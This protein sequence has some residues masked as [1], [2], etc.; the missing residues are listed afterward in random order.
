MVPALALLA[1]AAC[2]TQTDSGSAVGTP[3]ASGDT[4]AVST[5]STSTIPPTTS[6]TVAVASTTSTTTSTSTSMPP[7][8]TTTVPI[9]VGQFDCSPAGEAANTWEVRPPSDIPAP[10]LPE[11]WT[12]AIVGKSVQGRGIEVFVRPAESPR[13][14]V[15]VIGGVHGNEPVT[16]PA[17]RAM[18]EATIDPAI[19]VWL[20]P[21]ANPDGSAAGLRCNANGVDL[22]RN[23]AWEWRPEDGGP[24]PA[25]EPETQT[26]TLLVE[27][28]QPDLVVWVHQ[29]LGYV[30]AIGG[31]DPLLEQAWATA[32]GMAVR[33]G[34]TQHGGGESWSALVAGVPSMLIEI[35]GWESTPELV[36]SQV[37]GFEA[38]LLALG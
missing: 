2:S 25:S 1:L 32:A 17:V 22:N 21:T 7:T 36:A 23:F 37:A 18:V 4:P 15:L 33:V 8:T 28:L 34:V 31:T 13:R 3:A 19:E 6:T 11:G 35:D 38:M 12:T 26:L 30:S 5:T 20:L 29:P 24:G 16:P 9:P 10:D 27:R 14:K